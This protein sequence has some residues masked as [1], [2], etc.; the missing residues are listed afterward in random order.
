MDPSLAACSHAIVHFVVFLPLFRF[1]LVATDRLFSTNFF[2]PKVTLASIS[3]QSVGGHLRYV[4]FARL[5]SCTHFG[6]GAMRFMAWVSVSRADCLSISPIFL[7]LRRNQESLAPVN[8]YPVLFIS[9]RPRSPLHHDV[10]ETTYILYLFRLNCK[11]RFLYWC[12]SHI[13]YIVHTVLFLFPF[14]FSSALGH[15]R[16]ALCLTGVN[17]TFLWSRASSTLFTQSRVALSFPR[18]FVG[19]P[20]LFRDS[21]LKNISNRYRHFLRL[22]LTNLFLLSSINFRRLHA[23]PNLVDPCAKVYLF[24]YIYI[25]AIY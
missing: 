5:L 12:S 16:L 20:H 7:S 1:L 8:P 14:W 24:D 22:L 6:L 19:G 2:P 23:T 11:N 10:L 17:F 9:T 25:N 13:H 3:L 18:I 21:A 15:I 4:F